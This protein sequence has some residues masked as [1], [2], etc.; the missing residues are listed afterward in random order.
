[1]LVALS[2]LPYEGVLGALLLF[3]IAYYLL[4]FILALVLLALNEMVRRI[5][6]RER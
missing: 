6:R 5:R 4:P 3:R 2:S 1:M